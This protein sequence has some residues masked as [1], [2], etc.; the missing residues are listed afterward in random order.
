ML[1][2][3]DI[4]QPEE[5]KVYR[6]RFM[7]EEPEM[8]PAPARKE[9]QEYMD[10]E[11]QA[12]AEQEENAVS[13]E[14]PVGNEPVPSAV[15]C[16]RCGASLSENQ[17]FCAV[18]GQSCRKFCPQCG[19]SLI[20]GQPF[21]TRCGA[22]QQL[23]AHA[24][25]PAAVRPRKAP[26]P[27]IGLGIPGMV[28]GI[29]GLVFSW[30]PFFGLFFVIPGLILGIAARKKGC[31]GMATAAIVCSIIGLVIQTIFL[32]AVFAPLAGTNTVIAL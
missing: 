16:T 32:I 27:G 18:C 30:I 20:P 17:A 24:P 21:C 28:L 10:A 26:P 6:P 7:E 13:Q 19:A 14:I 8:L 5:E 9:T 1:D 3:K 31:Q 2:E 25:V 23:A 4:M 29:V 22:S 12:F 15:Y 11:E